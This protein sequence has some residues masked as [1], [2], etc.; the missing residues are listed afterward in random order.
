M[1]C[2]VCYLDTRNGLDL[3]ENR[4]ARDERVEG[5]GTNECMN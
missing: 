2:V 1:E 4:S 5:V 3:D